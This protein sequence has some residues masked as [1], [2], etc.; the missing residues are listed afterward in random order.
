MLGGTG[1]R[2][3]DVRASFTFC[4]VY[5]RQDQIPAAP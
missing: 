1:A 3:A 5:Q 2:K 4:N